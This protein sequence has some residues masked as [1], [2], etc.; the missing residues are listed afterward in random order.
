MAERDLRGPDAGRSALA[1][2]LN[3]LPA[4]W[5]LTLAFTVVLSAIATI[6]VV[7]TINLR[8]V[9]DAS[10]ADN[11]A[12]ALLEQLGLAAE[13]VVNGVEAVAAWEAKAWDAILMDIHMPEMDGVTATSSIRRR[14][15]ELGPDKTP[16]IA[17]TAS[18]QAEETR[19]YL[20]AGMDDCVPKPFETRVLVSALQG[21]L[22]ARSRAGPLARRP[23]A[24]RAA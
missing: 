14:E 1:A 19:G 5:K 7:L 2:R 13:C 18:V 8:V 21:V 12:H 11:H 9:E 6:E 3:D 22:A 17:V 16:I 10:A 23:R 24:P 4:T 20:S 15:V